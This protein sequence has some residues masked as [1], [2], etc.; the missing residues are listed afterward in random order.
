LSSASWLSPHDAQ[1][2]IQGVKEGVAN[3]IFSF[4][5]AIFI[6][7]SLAGLSLDRSPLLGAIGWSQDREQV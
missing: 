7:V 2:P 5:A 1:P 4:G 6:G 3:I